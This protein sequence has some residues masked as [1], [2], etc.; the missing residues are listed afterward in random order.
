MPGRGISPPAFHRGKG[1]RYT[2]MKRLLNVS[3]I[4]DKVNQLIGRLF[5]WILLPMIVLTSI[6]VFRRYVL[7]SPTVW[8]W[9]L[10]IQIWGLMLMACGGY[11]YWK[12]GFVRVDVLYDKFPQKLKYALGAITAVLVLV[13]MALT[14]RY[15]WNMFYASFTRNERIS[16][17]WGSPMWTIRFWVVL[18][19][20]LMFLQG[21]SELIKNAAALMGEIDLASNTDE[22]AEAIEQVKATERLPDG[23]AQE[24]KEGDA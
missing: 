17:V 6:E 15:G 19:S 5:S 12:G 1:E 20:G 7:N 24:G 18:G 3:N 23:G 10:I 11:C 13:C 22:V 21:V 4:I 2:S 8:A 9:E 16:S 14:F